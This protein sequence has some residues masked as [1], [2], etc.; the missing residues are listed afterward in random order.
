MDNF[1]ITC[2]CCGEKSN[3]QVEIDKLVISK[4]KVMHDLKE[5]FRDD[6]RTNRLFHCKNES[7]WSPFEAVI[8]NDRHTAILIQKEVQK[9]AWFIPRQFRL[10][11]NENDELY[12]NYFCVLFNRQPLKRWKD[13]YLSSLVDISLIEKFLLASFVRQNY[14]PSFFEAWPVND[15]IVWLPMDPLITS[16][17]KTKITERNPLCKMCRELFL[18]KEE[19]LLRQWLKLH[20]ECV[21]KEKCPVNNKCILES[22]NLASRDVNRC[23]LRLEIRRKNSPCYNSDLHI[24]ESVKQKIF[25]RKIRDY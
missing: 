1:T 6:S 10:R 18:K 21:Y 24:I 17:I 9:F 4:E 20:K 15:D 16:N 7:C 25:I 19:E 12:D 8:C 13:F 23:L 14:H 5:V 3:F 22:E 2:P 11:K